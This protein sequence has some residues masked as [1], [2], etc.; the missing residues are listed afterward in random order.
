[1]LYFHLHFSCITRYV[2]HIEKMSFVLENVR[3]LR[4]RM[5][6]TDINAVWMGSERDWQPVGAA[7][8][9]CP[10]G[11]EGT[12]RAEPPRPAAASSLP[13]AAP[14]AGGPAEELPPVRG[15][16]FPGSVTS[17]LRTC[18]AAADFQEGRGYQLLAPSEPP[19][20]FRP[21][22]HLHINVLSLVG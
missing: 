22:S 10:L 6:C 4:G 18:G 2:S 13:P 9:R 17:V 12:R 7:V 15:S 20:P 11:R 8:S 5:S 21:L 16:P 14:C 3:A 19:V 1:M